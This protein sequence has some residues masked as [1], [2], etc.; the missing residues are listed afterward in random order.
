MRTSPFA[1]KTLTTKIA[2][3]VMGASVAFGAMAA[4]ALKPSADD[5]ANY[6]RPATVPQP[7]NNLLTPERVELGK[8]LFFDPRLSG[9]NFISCA[10]CHNPALGWSDAQ[11]TAIGHGMG[12]LAR[13]SP[14]ILNTAYQPFMMWDGRFRTL[15]EQ[16]LGPIQ[17]GGEMAQPMNELIPEIKSIARYVQMFEAAYPGEG[18][19]KEGIGKAIASFE[20]SVV[21]TDSA[22]DRWLKGVDTA[23]SDSAKRGFE[24]FKGKANCV[25]CHSGFNFTDNGFH[26]IGLPD[27]KDEGR[28]RVKKVAVM[29]GAFKTPTLRDVALTAPYMHNGQYHTLTEVVEHYNRGGDKNPGTLDPNMKPLNLSKKEQ[30]ELVEFLKA[31]TGDAMAFTVPQLPVN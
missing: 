21:S 17:D 16:A 10:T 26:N 11:P 30:Q 18:V 27:S 8:F 22:F 14:T 7:A 4:D 28:Y 5:V 20:R 13:S 25:V 1:V 2:M 3:A 9:S 29:N 24:L 6:L 19:T 15:E 12:Q 23:M 31:L